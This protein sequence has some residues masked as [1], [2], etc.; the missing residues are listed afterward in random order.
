MI[1]TARAVTEEEKRNWEREWAELRNKHDQIAD[2]ISR[3][4]AT[5]QLDSCHKP[6]R[7]CQKLDPR[8]PPANLAC[9]FYYN[10]QYV[11]FIE[12]LHD[13]IPHNKGKDTSCETHCVDAIIRKAHT[14]HAIQSK[15]R[16]TTHISLVW[17]QH[18]RHA[19]PQNDSAVTLLTAFTSMPN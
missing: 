12:D 5:K 19:T 15:L 4:V 17:Y 6:L 11:Q 9:E 8:A 13:D 1:S 3:D 16:V 14:E 7:P 2:Y 18:T 10:A